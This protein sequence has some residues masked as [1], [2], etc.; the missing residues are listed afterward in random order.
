MILR[1]FVGM[2]IRLFKWTWRKLI[3]LFK[4]YSLVILF[5]RNTVTFFEFSYDYSQFSI[6]HHYFFKLLFLL[7]ITISKICW[8]FHRS[9]FVR[10][11]K[12]K[13]TY[14]FYFFK[15]D[16]AYL[17]ILSFFI[18]WWLLVYINIGLEI[19]RSL[20]RCSNTNYEYIIFY[21]INFAY[22]VSKSFCILV[23]W[24]IWLK[25]LVIARYV[26]LLLIC[27]KYLKKIW[28]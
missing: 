24:N 28:R 11:I 12:I 27:N 17:I 22:L 25:E 15:V 13:H 8:N 4:L 23:K 19:L 20:I 26:V 7:I 16:G 18:Y 1:V 3:A 2:N 6:I 14:F 9:Y 10:Y 5:V 21:I